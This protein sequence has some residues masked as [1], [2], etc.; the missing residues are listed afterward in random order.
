MALR[1]HYVSILTQEELSQ[2]KRLFDAAVIGKKCEI[3]TKL[4][5]HCLKKVMVFAKDDD[6]WLSLV[7]SFEIGTL[8]QSGWGRRFTRAT[9]GQARAA[10]A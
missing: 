6:A 4:H 2:F 1:E 10:P 3:Y 7:Y 8:H 5:D 9:T